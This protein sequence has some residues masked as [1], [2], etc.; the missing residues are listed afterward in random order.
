MK[1]AAF[2]DLSSGTVRFWVNIGE[3]FVGASVRREALHYR[4][5]PHSTT[6]D[7]LNTYQTHAEELAQAVRSR[8]AGGSR[9]PVMLRDQDLIP[10][11][12]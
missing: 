5:S 10:A 7:P 2:F 3:Q 9:E 11:Q 8:I 6:D 12:G 4:Y 1:P